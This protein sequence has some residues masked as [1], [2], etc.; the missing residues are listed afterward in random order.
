MRTYNFQC[1]DCNEK[2]NVESRYLVKKENLVCPN[3]SAKLS[4]DIFEKLKTA[5]ITLEEYDK[6]HPDVTMDENAKHFILNIQ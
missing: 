1:C 3:C 2:F 4:D 6:N 5:A